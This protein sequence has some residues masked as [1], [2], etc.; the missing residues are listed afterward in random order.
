MIFFSLL[1]R[2]T[3]GYGLIALGEIIAVFLG[4]EA[5]LLIF[6][7]IHSCLYVIIEIK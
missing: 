6:F 2:V 4:Y 5:I 3:S 1:W 7:F